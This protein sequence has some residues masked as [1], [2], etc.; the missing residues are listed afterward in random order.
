[1]YRAR[2]ARMIITSALLLQLYKLTKSKSV[3]PIAFFM[4]SAGAYLMAYD[5]YINDGSRFTERVTFKIFNATVLLAIAM[6]SRR[7]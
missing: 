3:C 1:M 6:M 2:V 4:W 5:Y 7:G